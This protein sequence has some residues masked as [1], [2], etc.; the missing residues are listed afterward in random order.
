MGGFIYG[1]PRDNFGIEDAGTYAVPS[2][3]G[4]VAGATATQ[5]FESGFT[6]RL[7][8]QAEQTDAPSVATIRD[9]RIPQSF[10]GEST[11]PAN[12]PVPELPKLSADEA[13]AKYGIKGPTPDTSLTFKNPITENAAQDLYNH[14]RAQ[15]LRMDTIQR[16]NPSALTSAPA[17]LVYS[18]AGGAL[19][20][21]NIGLA[22]IPGLGEANEA[23]IAASVGGGFLGRTA[24]RAASGV[25]AGAGQAA[26]L[27]PL[28]YA[29]DRAEGTPWDLGQA[30][31]D[32]AWGGALGGGLHVIGGTV[33]DA[34][35]RVR[36]TAPVPAAIDRL[37]PEAKQTLVQGAVAQ[38]MED[39]PIDVQPAFD[40]FQ[41]EQP[42]GGAVYEAPKPAAE[43]GSPTQPV[44][45]GAGQRI[46]VRPEVAELSDLIASH[47]PDGAINPD[48]PSEL[49]PRDRSSAASQSQIASI[50]GNL[51]PE[52]L[53]IGPDASVGAPIV[54]P[55]G[56]VES[57]N[58]RMAALSK[59][60]GDE[61]LKPQADAYRA[62]LESQG[63][64]TEG[65]KQPVLVGRRVTDL[66]PQERKAF[67]LGANER[68][69]LA[70]S[71]AERARADVD[72]VGKALDLWRGGDV[73]DAANR[74]F[75][76]S[77]MAQLSP[78]ER[79][80]MLLG[81]GG[82]SAEGTRRIQ[83]AILAGAYG[84]QLGPTL[85][86]VLNSDAEGMKNIAGALSDVAGVWG[87]MRALA[88]RGDI[89]LQMDLTRDLAEAVHLVEQARARGVRVRDLAMQSDLDRQPPTAEA[90]QLLG[91]F[92]RDPAL[93]KAAGRPVVADGLNRFATEAMK[94]QAGPGLFGDA[95]PSAQQILTAAIDRASSKG[96]VAAQ[97]L[98]A[99]ANRSDPQ[100]LA[101][102]R[103]AE[104]AGKQPQASK[105]SEALA[106]V[107]RQIA[108]IEAQMEPQRATEGTQP[109]DEAP[110][111]E[112]LADPDLAAAQSLVDLAEKRAAGLDQIAACPAV[113]GGAA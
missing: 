11:A 4:E 34:L 111:S 41:T 53:G 14:Q 1:A 85:D 95:G 100:R 97:D 21:S 7:Y 113:I 30:V 57:G 62:Y 108:D 87:Q 94:A 16:A 105:P 35:G 61:S 110:A 37:D 58:G 44:F 9:P 42:Q 96:A 79:G 72:R 81:H 3:A 17:R 67:T 23:R 48:Y 107:Q 102:D 59:V 75:V 103:A 65:I 90:M 13:N 10:A 54:G 28:N 109:G 49:Q 56:V 26:A 93:T 6:P 82:L 51:E 31:R 8:R 68:S 25:V 101:E 99:S 43:P 74:D 70:M 22:F 63:Y 112:L 24:A 15:N 71:A 84:D 32:V 2:T 89:P 52:R 73:G 50:A 86:R 33:A 38:A 19:D 45:T 20:P 46:E 78:E 18:L 83:G 104:D 92:Y 91:L 12:V 39:R 76:R 40:L 60:Y 47:T 36:P 27:E 88:A 77:F 98:F 64:S 106:D 29:L 80:N 55:D 5:A 66:S 69:T